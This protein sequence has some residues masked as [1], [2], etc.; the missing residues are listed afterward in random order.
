M[1][2]SYECWAYKNGSPYKMVHVVASSK[3]EAEQLA[4]AKF[5]SMGIEPEFVNCK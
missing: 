4:W 5:R 3:S 1:S 2:M